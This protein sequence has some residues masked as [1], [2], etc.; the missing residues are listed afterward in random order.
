MTAFA[1]CGLEAPV[2]LLV[3]PGQAK[4]IDAMCRQSVWMLLQDTRADKTKIWGVEVRDV[5]EA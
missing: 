3:R 1:V 5:A 4:L 2:A